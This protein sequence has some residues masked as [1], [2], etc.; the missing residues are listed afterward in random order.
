M[1]RRNRR[2][3]ASEGYE[4]GG[5]KVEK[6]KLRERQRKQENMAVSGRRKERK[7]NKCKAKTNQK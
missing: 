1:N 3:T 2:E 5:P 7:T 6:T 4:T